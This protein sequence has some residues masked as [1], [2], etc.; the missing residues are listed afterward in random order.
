M[1]PAGGG[2][3]GGGKWGEWVTLMCP[4]VGLALPASHDLP[5]QPQLE[6]DPFFST[7]HAWIHAMQGRGG[8]GGGG[9]GCTAG[10]CVRVMDLQQYFAGS[11][12]I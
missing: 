8:G 1:R 3:G 11:T 12:W 9:R 6:S 2:G 10:K 5:A 7:S 4:A